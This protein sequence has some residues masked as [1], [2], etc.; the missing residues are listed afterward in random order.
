MNPNTILWIYIVLL[1]AGGLVGF[2]KAKSKASIITSVSFAA[3]LSI[4]ATRGILDYRMRTI[5]AN[6]IL[7]FLLVFFGWRLTK[8]KKFMPNG[9]ML[10]L[11]LAALVLRNVVH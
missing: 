11:T 6:L 5:M 8:S 2:L 4:C 1:V 7:A 10:I 3:I 9:L